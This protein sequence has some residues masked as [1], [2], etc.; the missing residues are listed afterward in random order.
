MCVSDLDHHCPFV[1]TCV[2]PRNRIFFALF[3]LFAAIACGFGFFALYLP[4]QLAY[5]ENKSFLSTQHCYLVRYPAVFASMW[6]NLV[7]AM[8]VGYLFQF[9][10]V[11]VAAETT[12]YDS[13]KSK[14][15]AYIAARLNADPMKS[16]RHVCEFLLT[17]KHVVVQY[18]PGKEGGCCD[19]SG[20]GHS[21]DHDHADSIEKGKG[22]L[23]KG[24]SHAL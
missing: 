16:L 20:G 11:L 10:L 1:G 14:D 19:H 3:T 21:H 24:R 12:T 5:C 17:G 2:G 8:W 9:Q 6:A 23:E 15:G 13:L 4:L 22:G 18:L 7:V